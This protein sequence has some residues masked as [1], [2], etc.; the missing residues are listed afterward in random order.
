MKTGKMA[1][2]MSR[3]AVI[4]CCWLAV[5]ALAVAQSEIP[6][7]TYDTPEAAA[8]A[9]LDA[10]AKD[11]HQA[12]ITV[13]GNKFQDQLFI[14]EAE[15]EKAQFA[16]VANRAKEAM[17]LRQDDADTRVMVI[18]KNAWPMPIPIKHVDKGWQF[19]TATGIDEIL[20]RRVGADELAALD[21]L[22][23]Y[24]DAQVNYASDYRDGS[25]VEKYAQRIVSTPGHKDGLYWPAKEGEEQSPF[26][27]FVA[28]L[29]A[30]MQDR[31]L[32]KQGKEPYMGYYFRILTRQ[33]ENAPGGRYDYIINGNMIAGFAMIATPAEY[34]E[35]GIMTFVVNHQGKIFEKDL[36][37]DTALQAAAIQ[38]YNP[39]STWKLVDKDDQ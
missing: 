20:A 7:A 16:D 37:D 13:L 35:T 30:Y 24:V 36:G 9:L 18:G 34:G 2:H 14:D 22:K 10:L 1:I 33:G 26:G 15:R 31:D 27:P 29:P 39:D 6:A 28:E 17:Q 3:A 38:E 8:K 12:L 4:L 5:P 32:Q 25:D 23:A 19:D 21:V 11:D